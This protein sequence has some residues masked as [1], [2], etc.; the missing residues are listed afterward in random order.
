LTNY[1]ALLAVR[2]TV[3]EEL[4]KVGSAQAKAA[5]KSK[6]RRPLKEKK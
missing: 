5:P 1:R 4:A 3:P 2:R 6:L